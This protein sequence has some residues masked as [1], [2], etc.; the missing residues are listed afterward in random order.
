MFSGGLGISKYQFFINKR[1]SVGD[2]DL[3]P[4]DSNIFEPPVPVPDP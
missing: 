1:S 4:Q 2:P 3:D